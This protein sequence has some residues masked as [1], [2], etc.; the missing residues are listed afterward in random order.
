MDL[1]AI[2]SLVGGALGSGGVGSIATAITEALK[3]VNHLTEDDPVKQAKV[4]REFILKLVDIVKE[5]RKSETGTDLTDLVIA[6][7]KLLDA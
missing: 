5:A 7:T 6:I 2:G 1:S 4:N 3:L